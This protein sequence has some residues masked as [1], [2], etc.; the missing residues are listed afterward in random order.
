M[1]W[2]CYSR[3]RAIPNALQDSGYGAS[4]LPYIVND[5]VLPVH[6]NTTHGGALASGLAG[7]PYKEIRVDILTDCLLTLVG[8]FK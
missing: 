4:T 3:A 7:V 8:V 6:A 2:C 5:A 1:E